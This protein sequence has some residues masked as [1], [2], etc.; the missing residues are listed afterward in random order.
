[1]WPSGSTPEPSHMT[2]P[3]LFLLDL[4]LWTGAPIS[5]VYEAQTLEEFFKPALS[6]IFLTLNRPRTTSTRYSYPRTRH[7]KLPRSDL[8]RVEQHN[9]PLLQLT[10]SKAKT[11]IQI[12]EQIGNTPAPQS[13]PPS[14]QQLSPGVNISA[15]RVTTKRSQIKSRPPS[16]RSICWFRSSALSV[17]PSWEQRKKP[18]SL[19]NHRLCHHF[20]WVLS[21]LVKELPKISPNIVPLRH[22]E[23]PASSDLDPTWKLFSLNVSNQTSHRHICFWSYVPVKCNIYLWC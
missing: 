10:P 13:V 4:S 12:P 18:L 15:T 8:A 9:S 16:I 17:S 21:D 3:H 14:L 20:P 11:N 2:S 22:F 6:H 19:R 5:S 7:S 23:V 1:M